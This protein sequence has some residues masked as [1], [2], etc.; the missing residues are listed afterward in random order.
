MWTYHIRNIS[1]VHKLT[2]D[3]KWKQIT[4]GAQELKKKN[5]GRKVYLVCTNDPK[6][7]TGSSLICTNSSKHG[8]KS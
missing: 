8:N 1:D 3:K 5:K 6:W 4:S 2:K 7:G